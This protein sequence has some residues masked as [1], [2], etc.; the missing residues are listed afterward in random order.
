MSPITAWL[1]YWATV[2]MGVTETLLNL[3]DQAEG[4]D[5]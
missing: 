1:M 3:A 2:S 5:L 4:W